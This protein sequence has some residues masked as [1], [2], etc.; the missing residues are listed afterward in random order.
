[1]CRL[2]GEVASTKHFNRHL[3]RW[4]DI[5]DVNRGANYTLQEGNFV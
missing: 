2:C 3:E 1:M 4:H 5:T